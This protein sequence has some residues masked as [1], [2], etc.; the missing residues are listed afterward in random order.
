[1]FLFVRSG[2]NTESRSMG[3]MDEGD[4]IFGASAEVDLDHRFGS[5]SFDPICVFSMVTGQ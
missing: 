5:F 3:A 4:A 2:N 1:M